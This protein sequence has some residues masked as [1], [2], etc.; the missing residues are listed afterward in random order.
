MTTPDFEIRPSLTLL[1]LIIGSH[2][3]VGWVLWSMQNSARLLLP[4]VIG[5]AIFYGLRDGL[6]RLPQ[7]IC[8]VW[9]DTEGWH[10]QLRDGRQ[11][12]PFRLH[13]L[14][15]VDARFIRLSLNGGVFPQ[16]LLLTSGMIGAEAFR[17]LQVFL[18]WSS[19]KHQA[20]GK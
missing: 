8:R 6:K 19:D 12:G 2:S 13:S 1:V 16:H 5:S 15:R 4:I 10:W 14:S 18:R 11:Q 9:L 20:S 17:H 3:A 7:S